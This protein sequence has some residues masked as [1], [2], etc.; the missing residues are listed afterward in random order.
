MAGRVVGL[1]F[2]PLV[3]VY[4]RRWVSGL[5][6]FPAKEPLPTGSRRFESFSPRQIFR[7]VVQLVERVVWDHEVE[8]SRPS[9]PTKQKRDKGVYS[10]MTKEQKISAIQT[11]IGL[12]ESRTEKENKSIVNKLKRKMRALEKQ[13]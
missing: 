2:L 3:L 8:G 10:T 4:L 9:Y 12:L 6:Q 11:R 5:N 7:V 1:F 13:A